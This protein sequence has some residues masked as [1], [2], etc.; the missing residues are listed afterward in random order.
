M[1][2]MLIMLIML[3]MF[4]LMFRPP[5]VWRITSARAQTLT[6]TALTMEIRSEMR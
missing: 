4:I 5:S 3:I 6:M 1:F 2:I